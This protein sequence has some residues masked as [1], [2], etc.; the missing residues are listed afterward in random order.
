MSYMNRPELNSD[1]GRYDS[2]HGVSSYLFVVV[3]MCL[4][5]RT[6]FLILYWQDASS[7]GGTS[8]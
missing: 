8:S 6:S 3:R 1:H 2:F 7:G 4:F 5:F